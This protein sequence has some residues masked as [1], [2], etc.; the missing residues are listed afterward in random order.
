MFD[1]IE[2][3]AESFGQEEEM[4]NYLDEDEL[5]EELSRDLDEPG[6]VLDAIDQD[7]E[8]SPFS[9]APYFT[10]GISFDE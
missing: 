9:P 8:D 6:H 4:A 7:G 3:H 2:K 1:D 10:R 5:K